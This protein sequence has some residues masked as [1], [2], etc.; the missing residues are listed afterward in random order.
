MN[1]EEIRRYIERRMSDV[2]LNVRIDNSGYQAIQKYANGDKERL[3]QLYYKLVSVGSR[4]DRREINGATIQVALDDLRRMNQFLEHLPS[5][6]E[7]G[8]SMDVD[9]LTIEQLAC[10]LEQKVAEEIESAVAEARKKATAAT[11]SEPAAR[12]NGADHSDSA[13]VSSAATVETRGTPGKPCIL[14]VDDSPTIR[15]A[16]TKALENDFELVEASDGEKGWELLCANSDI[17]L[18]VTDLMMPEMD[19]FALIERI[20]GAK[21][22]N[23]AG[24]PIIVVTAL[25]D[26]QAK[27]HA[28]MAGAN[29]FITKRTDTLEL[30]ARVIARYQLSQIVGNPKYASGGNEG[31]TSKDLSP[32][33][34]Q[35]AAA[36][37]GTRT[38]RSIASQAM[39]APGTPMRPNHRSN[40]T[41]QSNAAAAYIQVPPRNAGN[42]RST[43][44]RQSGTNPLIRA[45]GLHRLAKLSS[46]ALITLVASILVVTVIL[47]VLYVNGGQ[48]GRLPKLQDVA[49]S[50]VSSSDSTVATS[51][52]GAGTTTTEDPVSD[53]GDTAKNPDAAQIDS[54]TTA[55][56]APIREEPGKTQGKT[57]AEAP[58]PDDP[59]DAASIATATTAKPVS[60][61]KHSPAEHA[62]KPPSKPASTAAADE[63]PA[64]RKSPA[65]APKRQTPK[66]STLV[67][68]VPPETV[69]DRPPTEST[70]EAA[71]PSVTVVPPPTTPASP[72]D[73]VQPGSETDGTAAALAAGNTG[74]GATLSV[75]PSVAMPGVEAP[76]PNTPDT[77]V[78]V[79]RAP[80]LSTPP[81]SAKLT[82]AELSN[83]LNRFVAV[84]E[85]GDIQQFLSLFSDNVRTNDRSDKVGLRQDYEALFR[86]TSAR[87]MS[88]GDIVWDIDNREAQGAGNFEVRVR[89]A[90]DGK[91][92]VY[93]GSLTFHVRQINGRLEITRMY[94]GQWKAQS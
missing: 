4:Q 8:D 81:S 66:A 12:G 91:L 2:G 38:P 36:L 72:P 6:P 82:Q 58:K 73:T 29:D 84:Y 94:H 18:V 79:A 39:R 13:F 32:P 68:A 77:T 80:Q 34:H 20:R 22:E 74:S 40:R 55:D 75:E 57:Q 25:E 64:V 93:R 14:V 33:A 67:A 63:V 3:N 17:K 11:P 5:K 21:S 9:R 49:T 1:L 92:R 24:L 56:G 52:S 71:S 47:G 42:S 54:W 45:M 30:Q 70:T 27:V 37:L 62:T 43:R 50:I 60:P 87:Q 76:V 78:A 86:T 28:L 7:Q 89:R 53:A 35:V 61:P 46:T 23:V 16:V 19:G 41:P 15:A 26:P 48:I 65:P 10:N 44:T 83:L 88:L 31:R 90:S 85:A 69:P 51:D 59:K